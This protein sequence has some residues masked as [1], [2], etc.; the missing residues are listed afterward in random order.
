MLGVVSSIF[1]EGFV[2]VKFDELSFDVRVVH[3]IVIGRIVAFI[4]FDGSSF[5]GSLFDGLS[6][7]QLRYAVPVAH[8]R[9]HS[10]ASQC[11]LSVQGMRK[12]QQQWTFCELLAKIEVHSHATKLGT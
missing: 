10:S 7:D 1:Y 8:L 4:T 11:P 3:W 2:V 6:F 9:N 5:D 12:K